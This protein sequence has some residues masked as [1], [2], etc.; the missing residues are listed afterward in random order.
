M[1]HKQTVLASSEE[2]VVIIADPHAFNR[3]AVSLH[4]VN[5]TELRHLEDMNGTRFAF[6]TN[7]RNQRLLVGRKYNLRKHDACIKPVLDVLTVPNFAVASH[8]I[9]LKGF[10]WDVNY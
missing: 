8:S 2:E 5:F 10:S 3:L 6:L 9:Y 1:D 4:L 7:T